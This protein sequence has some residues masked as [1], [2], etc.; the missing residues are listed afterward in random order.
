MTPLKFYPQLHET[1]WGGRRIA[2]FKQGIESDNPHIGESWELSGVPGA[3]S[4]VRG[5]EFDGLTLKEV[6][7]RHGRE[8]LGERIYAQYEGQ[9]PLLFKFIDAHDDLSIQVHPDDRMAAEKHGKRGKNEMWYVIEAEPGSR[10]WC[11]WKRELTPEKYDRVVKEGRIMEYLQAHSVKAGDLFYLP[12]GRIHAIGAGLLIAEIQQASDVT[13]RVY[14]FDRRD[15]W[16]NPRELH[17]ELAREALDYHMEQEYRTHYSPATD[18][19]VALVDSPFFTTS[20]YELTRPLACDLSE[21]ESFVALIVVEGEGELC[22]DEGDRLTLAQ[23]ETI[24]VAA[25]T[26]SITLH[27]HSPKLKLLS[28]RIG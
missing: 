17:T 1:L 7:A 15:K 5:G 11:G 8:L 13:Y 3:E 18:C 14:D 26:R 24:L 12:A 25:S 23:G 22:T 6:L 2:S 4:V 16:G 19:E 21:V 10:L 20:L 28:C 9:F 27:P